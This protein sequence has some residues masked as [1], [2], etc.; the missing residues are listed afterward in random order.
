MIP[1]IKPYYSE[2]EE[3]AA[4]EVIRSGWVS[5]GP[6][7][8]EF[9]D[10]ISDYVSANYAVA[11]TSC[12]SALF[13]AL[14]VLNIGDG[15]EVLVPSYSFIA[16]ANTVLHTG[17]KPVFIDIDP[18]TY[19][20]DPDRIEERI[21]DNT[22]AIMPVH[23]AG[24]PADMDRIN[25]IAGRYDIPVIEDAAC[26]IGS[27]YKDN[28]IGC[29]DNL[30]CFSFHPRKIIT[31]GEGGAI[32]SNNKNYED[33]LRLL[34]H[35]GMSVSDLH[36]H[37]SKDIIFEEYPV[38][39][40]NFRLTDIQAAVGIVQMKKIGEIIEKRKNIAEKYNAAFRNVP[41]LQIPTVPERTEIAYQSYI[42]RI[43]EDSPCSRNEIMQKLMEKEIASRRGI[44]AIHREKP[45]KD[46]FDASSL[47]Q[48][49][50]AV[51]STIILPL[52]PQMSEKE[53]A[54]VIDS[55]LEIF[56]K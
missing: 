33:D 46:L 40:Y 37:S 36:R 1:I 2:E 24:I 20:M 11:V 6:K 31:C 30:V 54:Q 16:T 3:Q 32:A 12:T 29:S 39:G 41:Y 13:L 23:Q 14:K 51:D 5:Q 44:M 27:V 35:Q 21:T 25:E 55:I 48:T 26:A 17:A 8:K 4:A 42:L 34:R 45:Y 10:I 9:E 49:D 43:S 52:Y 18:N 19:N 15:D 50:R 22:K 56:E 47:T 38:V 53:Q 7:V 28:K